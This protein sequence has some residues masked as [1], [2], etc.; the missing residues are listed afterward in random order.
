MSKRRNNK[1][2][3]RKNVSKSISQ[4]VSEDMHNTGKS[5]VKLDIDSLL[6]YF[7]PWLC[8]FVLFFIVSYVLMVISKDQVNVW[9]DTISN[10]N[11]LNVFVSLIISV[12]LETIWYNNVKFEFTKLKKAWTVFATGIIALGFFFYAIFSSFETIDS[13]NIILSVKYTFNLT[14]M[15]ITI[16]LAIAI[17]VLLSL[18]R[19]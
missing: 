10:S 15:I 6:H 4:Q 8:V 3:I 19:K 9:H 17:F 2:T 14:Y 1:G 5:F 16:V 12:Y 11:M 18:Y 13:N 7:L